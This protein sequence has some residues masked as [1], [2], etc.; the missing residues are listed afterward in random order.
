MVRSRK[1]IPAALRPALKRAY[2]TAS[3]PVEELAAQ[4]GMSRMTFRIRARELGWQKP[5]HERAKK[6]RGKATR[7]SEHAPPDS[8][9][10]AMRIRSNV[11]RELTAFERLREAKGANDIAKFD[12]AA[13]MLTGLLRSL[14]EAMRLEQ[15]PPRQEPAE[16]DEVPRDIEELRRALLDRVEKLAAAEADAMAQGVEQA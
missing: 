11:E 8:R 5:E 4:A 14:Q 7:I 1:D 6:T 15:T 10:L 3:Q 9:A 2:E 16:A 12:L 13:R